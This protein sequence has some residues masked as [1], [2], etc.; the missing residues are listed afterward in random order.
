ML[1][2]LQRLERIYRTWWK[3]LRFKVIEKSAKLLRSS[4]I[5]WSGSFYQWCLIKAYCIKMNCVELVLKRHL[6]QSRNKLSIWRPGRGFLFQLSFTLLGIT[7]WT[8]IQSGPQSSHL[9]KQW[10]RQ[11]LA[12]IFFG[13]I[14]STLR[15]TCT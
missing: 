3:W 1:W 13:H 9:K 12:A 2:K 10:L 8:C 4:E 6:L 11:S 7:G 5:F 14:K 15:K